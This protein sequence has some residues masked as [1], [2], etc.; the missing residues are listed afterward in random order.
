MPAKKRPISHG[1]WWVIYEMPKCTMG[2]IQA[3]EIQ[4]V[5]NN[6]TTSLVASQASLKGYAAES[7][8]GVEDLWFGVINC[9][10]NY[11]YLTTKVNAAKRRYSIIQ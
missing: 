7:Y 8:P 6:F 1:A 5:L 11:F 9:D 2:I 3:R 10:A 4:A